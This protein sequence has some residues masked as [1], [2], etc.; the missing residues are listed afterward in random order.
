MF[1]RDPYI[2]RPA[3]LSDQSLRELYWSSITPPYK[4]INV[5]VEFFWKNFI[6]SL[7]GMGKVTMLSWYKVLET[8]FDNKIIELTPYQQYLFFYYYIYW[9]PKGYSNRKQ[10][11][12]RVNMWYYLYSY[13]GWR[14]LFGHPVNGQRTWSNNKTRYRLT[15][16]VYDYQLNRF[17][18]K[19][20]IHTKTNLKI[21]FLAEH[22]NLLWQFEWYNE[23]LSA[24]QIFKNTK[25]KT[26]FFR[27]RVNY[28]HIMNFQISTP[29]SIEHKKKKKIE[30]K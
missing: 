3:R 25:Q 14:H 19:Y 21:S 1:I 18:Q 6:Q 24:N 9:F 17:Q 8:R 28:R 27:L 11:L 15:N 22:I 7:Y 5:S 10:I 23:W 20:G 12:F 2:C 30:K 4:Y 29:F 16:L 13:K 26:K